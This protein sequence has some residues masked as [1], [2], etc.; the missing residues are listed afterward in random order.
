[1]LWNTF[2]YQGETLKVNAARRYAR[3]FCDSCHESGICTKKELAFRYNRPT[4]NIPPRPGSGSSG[5]PVPGILPLPKSAR[6]PLNFWVFLAFSPPNFSD[7]NR[8]P[9]P[10]PRFSV[11]LP[12]RHPGR[13]YGL[14]KHPRNFP[15]PAKQ[16]PV[17][18]PRIGGFTH[19]QSRLHLT[20][21]LSGMIALGVTA[22]A[23]AQD[24]PSPTP[25]QSQAGPT[26][27]R[28]WHADGPQSSAR[29]LTSAL[30]L[31]TDQQSRSSPCSSIA[32]RRCRH[33]CRTNHSH[34]MT[35]APRR[36]PSPREQTTASRH[37]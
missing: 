17:P 5:Q 18:H 7:F 32:S 37:C 36:A 23:F 20:W 1:M 12:E 13:T 14:G 11:Y 16:A 35:A 24:T 26:P 33:S 31:T 10:R 3:G 28:T 15:A 29:A 21:H 25:R 22:V 9:H 6:P 19:M 4:L 30:S 2:L 27:R 34:R 8:R